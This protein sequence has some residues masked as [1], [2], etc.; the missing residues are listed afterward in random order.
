MLQKNI[1][2]DE[3]APSMRDASKPK[4]SPMLDPL[5]IGFEIMVRDELWVIDYSGDENA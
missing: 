2:A 3:P 4:N 5:P 1:L